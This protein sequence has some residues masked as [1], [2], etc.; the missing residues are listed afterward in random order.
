M[1]GDAGITAFFP[2]T[3]P[4]AVLSVIDKRALDSLAAIAQQCM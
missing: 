4:L 3:I 2:V 1:A